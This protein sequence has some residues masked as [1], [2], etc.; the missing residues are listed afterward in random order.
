MIFAVFLLCGFAAAIAIRTLDPLT[1]EI[2]SDLMIPVSTVVLLGSAMSAVDQ[3]RIAQRA[4]DTD[5]YTASVIDARL[6]ELEP[7]AR[8]EYEESRGAARP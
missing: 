7:L 1:V 5:F 8:R 4:G 2:A 6:R 3:L